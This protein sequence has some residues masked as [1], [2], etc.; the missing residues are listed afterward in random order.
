MVGG[1]SSYARGYQPMRTEGDSRRRRDLT[2][3]TLQEHKSQV[4]VHPI[5][6]VVTGAEQ[7]DRVPKP[8]I[9]GGTGPNE[10]WGLDLRGQKKPPETTRGP[11]VE[12]VLTTRQERRNIC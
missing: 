7:R 3:P 8:T 12:E 11:Q 1:Q 4:S 10:S 6:P 2:E 5:K 9:V